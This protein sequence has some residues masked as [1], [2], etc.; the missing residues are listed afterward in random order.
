MLS[1]VQKLQ[2]VGD[3]LAF[4]HSSNIRGADR[5]RELRRRAG[6]SPTRGFYRRVDNLLVV[7]AI[8][9]EA[10][11]DKRGFARSVS[12][13]EERLAVFSNEGWHE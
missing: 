3:R 10:L 4:P 5:I 8:G 1:A 11:V 2:V 12:A 7:A 13:A 6:R 9:P